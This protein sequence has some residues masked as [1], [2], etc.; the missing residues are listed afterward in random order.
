[1]ETEEDKLCRD[2]DVLQDVLGRDLL[3]LERLIDT[4]DCDTFRRSYCRAIFALIDATTEW[5][6][7]YTIYFN[8][9]G[10]LSNDEKKALESRN[11]ALLSVFT[12]INLFAVTSGAKTSMKK[13]SKEWGVLHSSIK[14]RNRITHP[15]YPKDIEISDADLSHLRSTKEVFISV[16]TRCLVDSARALINHAETIKRNWEGSNSLNKTIQPPVESG[17]CYCR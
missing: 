4:E 7:R 9:P 10:L 17:S 8:S 2:W 15:K 3:L 1:M 12:A 13:N 5:M 6:K 11:G 16:V 14:I